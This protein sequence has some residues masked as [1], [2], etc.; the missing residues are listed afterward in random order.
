M[1]DSAAYVSATY[2][3]TLKKVHSMLDFGFKTRENFQ[4][5][6]ENA[7]STGQHEALVKMLNEEERFWLVIT[8]PYM[9]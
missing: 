9:K 8:V 2:Y 5:L 6:L 3:P 7:Y 4:E 1:A